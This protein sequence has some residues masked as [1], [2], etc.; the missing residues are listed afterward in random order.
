MSLTSFD[1][2][3]FAVVHGLFHSNLQN[4]K[5]TTL[6]ILQ[7]YEG[8]FKEHYRLSKL[9]PKASV[10][11]QR[12]LCRGKTN[13]GAKKWTKCEHRETGNVEH[14]CEMK[15]REA[16]R[17]SYFLGTWLFPRTCR[18]Q[19][20]AS[21]RSPRLTLLRQISFIIPPPR[22]NATPIVHQL[23]Y[24]LRFRRMPHT[25]QCLYLVSRRS[26]VSEIICFC[27]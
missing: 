7:L 14:F 21:P 27:A 18:L 13:R 22:C 10:S 16:S 26:L 24:T 6:V 17:Y 23:L 9:I 8:L 25:C 1:D 15:T 19:L 4:T 11:H 2:G 20:G 3:V 5:N 12:P